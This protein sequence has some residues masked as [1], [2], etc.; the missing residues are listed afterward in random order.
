MYQNTPSPVYKESTDGANPKM[1]KLL[2]EKKSGRVFQDR[3]HPDW[4]ENYELYRNKVKTN[5]LTQRQA[6]NIPL[7]KETVKTILAGIDDVPTVTWKEKSG[8]QMK[9]IIYQELWNDFV[10]RTKWELIDILEK[11]NVLLYGLT[12]KT[13][14]VEDEGVCMYPR[15]VYDVIYDPLMNPLDIETARF[16]VH[17]NIFKTLREVLADERYSQ[18]GKDELKDFMSSPKGMVISGQNKEE[19]EKKQARLRSKIGRAHV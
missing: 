7:V 15:D 5:R 11:K 1:S 13:L 14:N 9:E 3:K 19:W 6:V 16:I 10:K 8:D 17:Q 2:D 18:K 12:T 4:D